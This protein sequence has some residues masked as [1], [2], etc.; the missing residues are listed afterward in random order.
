VLGFGP[1]AA[2]LIFKHFPA[3]GKMVLIV[4]ALNLVAY[5]ATMA[6][7]YGLSAVDRAD[8][9]FYAQLLGMLAQVAVSLWLVRAFALPGA[10]AAMLVGS[11]VVLGVRQI[12]YTREMRKA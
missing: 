10:A 3:N 6:Q 1:V 11:V 7:S 8:L 9:T 12:F 2:R 4:L 5:A